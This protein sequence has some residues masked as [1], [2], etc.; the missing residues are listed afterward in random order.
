MFIMKEL[1]VNQMKEIN[2]GT[3]EGVLCGVAF[4]QLSAWNALAFGLAGVYLGTSIDIGL[5][6][7]LIGAVVCG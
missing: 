5:G 3:V 7:D 6:I 4:T 1:N 2:G